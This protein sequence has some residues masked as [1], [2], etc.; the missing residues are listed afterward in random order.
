[1]TLIL[2]CKL[3]VFKGNTREMYTTILGSKTYQI[4]KF[5]HKNL[6]LQLDCLYVTFCYECLSFQHGLPLWPP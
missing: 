2:N 1:M 6:N 5:Y 3:D 4:K